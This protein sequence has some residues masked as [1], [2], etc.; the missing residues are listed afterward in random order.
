MSLSPHGFFLSFMLLPPPPSP[1]LP[2]DLQ[3][4]ADRS[5]TVAFSS[6]GP[7]STRTIGTRASRAS[8]MDRVRFED[9]KSQTGEGF[10]RAET[11]PPSFLFPYSL[12]SPLRLSLCM[13]AS[14]SF[15]PFLAP[16]L[17]GSLEVSSTVSWRRRCS[18]RLLFYCRLGEPY[19]IR[20][21]L[22]V[23]VPCTVRRDR[24]R[25]RSITGG[26]FH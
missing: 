14:P 9:A 6:M 10:E 18:R 12:F 7:I 11:P 5:S 15:F 8:S 19:C 22:S 4:L 21:A 17:D 20:M 23:A 25:G 26:D 13:D 2:G 1:L 3:T 16:R 24:Q